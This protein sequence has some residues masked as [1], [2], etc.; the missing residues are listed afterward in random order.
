MGG[1]T[2]LLLELSQM[3]QCLLGCFHL[4]SG[5]HFLCSS[6]HHTQG[7]EGEHTELPGA[8]SRLHKHTWA[9]QDENV[10]V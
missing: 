10:A 6:G 4:C 7:V 3:L 2:Q 9:K 8:H 1:K 5:G